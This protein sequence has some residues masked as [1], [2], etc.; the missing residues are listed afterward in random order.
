MRSGHEKFYKRTT[1]KTHASTLSQAD[2][3]TVPIVEFHAL[4]RVPPG[5]GNRQPD[6]LSLDRPEQRKKKRQDKTTRYD[7]S[8]VKTENDIEINDHLAFRR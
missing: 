2:L 4:L 6:K 1:Y 3:G 8:K 7:A 5:W